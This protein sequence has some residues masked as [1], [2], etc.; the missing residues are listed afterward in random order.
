M[1]D[2]I[3]VAQLNSLDLLFLSLSLYFYEQCFAI[4]W[5]FGLYLQCFDTLSMGARNGTG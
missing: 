1:S 3:L 4:T 5:R 2:A